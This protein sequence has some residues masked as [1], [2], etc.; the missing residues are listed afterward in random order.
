[1]G[2]FGTEH[3]WCVDQISDD[4]DARESNL[5]LNMTVSGSRRAASGE[6]SSTNLIIIF[7]L[8]SSSTSWISE[9]GGGLAVKVQS[10]HESIAKTGYDS[11]L[12]NVA[13]P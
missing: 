8:H 4:N 7:G 5:R 1:M 12:D 10:P 6:R 2:R 13:I 9:H 11:S 3:L